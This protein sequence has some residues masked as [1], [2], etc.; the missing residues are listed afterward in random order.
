MLP[1]AAYTALGKEYVRAVITKNFVIGKK[2]LQ[3]K[4]E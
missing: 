4:L 1:Y 2:E 3:Q